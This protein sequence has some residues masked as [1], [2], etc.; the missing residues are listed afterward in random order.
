MLH[1][2][3]R[4]RAFAAIIKDN[5]ILMVREETDRK[6]FWTLPGGGLENAESFE[7]AVIREVREEVNLDVKVIKYLFSRN[8]EHGIEKCYLV[9]PTDNKPPTLGYDP[10]LP[11]DNQNLKEVAWHSLKSMKDDLQVSEVIKALKI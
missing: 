1:L 5:L 9:E 6:S 2:E 10:E 11:M 3:E 8:Y 4:P 7:E